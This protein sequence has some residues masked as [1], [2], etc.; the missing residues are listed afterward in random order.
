MTI[1]QPPTTPGGKAAGGSRAGSVT[2][3]ATGTVTGSGPTTGTLP[4]TPQSTSELFPQIGPMEF[5]IGA[6]T[7]ATPVGTGKRY[8]SGTLLRL[9]GASSTGSGAR[10]FSPASA[11][12]LAVL[13]VLLAYAVGAAYSLLDTSA[14]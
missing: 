2:V 12:V 6:T 8:A 13:V 1:G 4:A 14:T 11:W 10:A 3:V 5:S 7:T 9:V